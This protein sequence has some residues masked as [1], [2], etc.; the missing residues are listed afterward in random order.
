M[1]INNLYLLVSY[2][3]SIRRRFGRFKLEMLTIK[4]S[5]VCERLLTYHS[6]NQECTPDWMLQTMG[7]PKVGRLEGLQIYGDKVRR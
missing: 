1:K 2:Y 7:S 4:Q 3:D 5:R 6:D